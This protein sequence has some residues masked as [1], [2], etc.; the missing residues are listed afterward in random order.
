[1]LKQ[2][3]VQWTWN[4]SRHGVKAPSFDSKHSFTL[5]TYV[6][7]S[8]K[9]PTGIAVY[10][11]SDA[12]AELCCLLG[13]PS[14]HKE[15]QGQKG[16]SKFVQKAILIVGFDC[17]FFFRFSSSLQPN[18]QWAYFTGY[19]DLNK[20]AFPLADEKGGPH[21]HGPAASFPEQSQPI[22]WSTCSVPPL[23]CYMYFFPM[24]LTQ[25]NNNGAISPQH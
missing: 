8:F 1:M 5:F 16:W 22:R 3:V 2:V 12:M 21:G 25:H 9:C 6:L 18:F 10:W 4:M 24:T 14:I 13:S 11:D 7:K 23:C 20:V 15:I 17:G 19:P